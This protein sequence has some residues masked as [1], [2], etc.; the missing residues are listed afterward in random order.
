MHTV[1]VGG[2]IAGLWIA[3]QLVERG[4][5]VSVLDNYHIIG[6]RIN[7]AKEGYE[8]GAGRIFH[9]HRRVLDLIKHYGLQTIP[10][11]DVSLWMPLGSTEEPE[12]NRFTSVWTTFLSL[13]KQLDP[14]VLA[15]HTLRQL[16]ESILGKKQTDALLI[17]YPYRAEVD[18]LRADIALHAFE[19]EMG[20]KG[21]V[22][23]KNGLIGIINGLAADIRK[24]GGTIRTKTTVLNVDGE[25]GDFRVHVERG[26]PIKA[27]R[28]VFALHASALKKIPTT[29]NMPALR[30]LDMSPLIRI[31][32]SYP[33]L[34][35]PYKIITDSP[36]R[37]IIPIRDDI[38]MI[39]YTDGKDTLTW[40]GLS[41]SERA[42]KIHKEVIRLF[43]SPIEKPKWVRATCW[44]DGT[45]VWTPGSY[46]PKELSVRSL[47]VGPGLY[48]CGESFSVYHQAWI[49]GALEHAERLLE[50][51]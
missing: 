46:D 18:K 4:D 43:G 39:S 9:K 12:P 6:G 3:K 16:A 48:C 38:V 40:R 35:L 27:D 19:A 34:H 36:L 7:T 28:V 22:V 47:K 1:I 2:G 30:H 32:A 5:K 21:Y 17:Q 14:A 26:A 24:A 33:G 37:H 13:I 11:S 42:N 49:E 45:T 25:P 8:L 50:I 29:K 41:D 15:N 20:S 51:I 31:Y 23:V 44:S 10:I